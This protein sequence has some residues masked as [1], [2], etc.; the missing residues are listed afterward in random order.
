MAEGKKRVGLHT[1]LHERCDALDLGEEVVADA[2]QP[3]TGL[4]VEVEDYGEAEHG[5]DL[6]RREAVVKAGDELVPAEHGGDGEG[7]SGQDGHMQRL[8]ELGE[9]QGK[10]TGKGTGAVGG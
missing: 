5:G 4:R 10:G 3:L 8:V 6:V 9:T 1:A 7:E 2:G